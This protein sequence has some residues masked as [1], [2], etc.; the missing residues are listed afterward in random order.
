MSSFS[1]I[2]AANLPEPKP[3][4]GFEGAFFHDVEA[5]LLDELGEIV[6][7]SDSGNP[8]QAMLD[9]AVWLFRCC[10]RDAEGKPFDDMQTEEGV[11][12]IPVSQV[13]RLVTKGL[14]FFRPDEAGDPADGGA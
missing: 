10:I 12:K 11:R 13:R 8:R 3:V 1:E 14:E 2:S 7:G 9:I 4:D 6:Q 5:G